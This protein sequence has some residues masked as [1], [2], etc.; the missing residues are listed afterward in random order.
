MTCAFAAPAVNAIPHSAIRIRSFT[1]IE[2]SSNQTARRTY[3]LELLAMNTVSGRDDHHASGPR[4]GD[5]PRRG[6]KQPGDRRGR[7]LPHV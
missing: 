3:T 5:R 7:Y 2:I 4:W 6:E 1:L